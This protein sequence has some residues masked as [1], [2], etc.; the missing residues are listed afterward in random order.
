M[1]TNNVSGQNTPN[2]MYNDDYLSKAKP[3]NKDAQSLF[4]ALSNEATRIFEEDADVN[5][6]GKVDKNDIPLLNKLINNL[7][8]GQE[9]LTKYMQKY[10]F[11]AYSVR[12]GL[13]CCENT[14]KTIVN[15]ITAGTYLTRKE[16]LAKIE[17]ERAAEAER[18]AE[19]E[20]TKQAE[21]AALEPDETDSQKAE[22]STSKVKITAET[23]RIPD[24]TFKYLSD[25]KRECEQIKREYDK[26]LNGSYQSNRKIASNLKCFQAK[27]EKLL[28]EVA[29][30]IRNDGQYILEN[31][32]DQVGSQIRY[33]DKLAD[34]DAEQNKQNLINTLSK[35]PEQPSAEQAQAHGKVMQDALNA[36]RQREQ[37]DIDEMIHGS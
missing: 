4:N 32:Y 17:A 35:V 1:A 28:K 23:L 19:A 34:K 13:E 29:P 20:R 30:S 8:K 9:I 16:Q 24:R 6:D 7:H 25:N 2:P 27:Y 22:S 18:I 12:N 33:Y 36:Q 26:C 5:G 3:K 14:I 15:D 10:N 37:K 21:Q 31:L 11:D